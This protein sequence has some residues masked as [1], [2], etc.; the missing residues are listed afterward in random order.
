MSRGPRRK[1]SSRAVQRERTRGRLI[2]ATVEEVR[3]TGLGPARIDAIARAAFYFHFPTKD[4]VLLAVLADSEH[5]VAARITALPPGSSLDEVVSE[6]AAAIAAEWQEDPALLAAVGAVALRTTAAAF[7]S[8]GDHPA[9]DAL[10]PR[11][12]AA[13]AKGALD[14]ALPPTNLAD[15]LLVTLFAAA[16]SWTARP[17]LPLASVLEGVSTFFLRGCGA[18]VA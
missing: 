7:P 12:E 2:E 13:L 16:T 17:E 8:F 3:R 10:V 11:F 5:R 4:D 9:R 14:L 6:T 18:G 1:P 15:F